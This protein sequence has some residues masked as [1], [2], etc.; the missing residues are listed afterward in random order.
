MVDQKLSDFSPENWK[1]F[2]DH[3]LKIEE[4][5]FDS[6]RVVDMQTDGLIIIGNHSDTN[7]DKTDN[8]NL[9]EAE[10]SGG[11]VYDID[12]IESLDKNL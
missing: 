8:E 2:L 5:Y 10:S 7:D 12:S 1:K 9:R 6:D 4:D 3:V 11:E